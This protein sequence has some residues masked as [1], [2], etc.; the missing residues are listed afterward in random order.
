MKWKVGA[1]VHS[2]SRAAKAKLNDNMEEAN[3]NNANSELLNDGKNRYNNATKNTIGPNN[4]QRLTIFLL[5]NSMIGSGILNQPYVFMKSGVVGALIGF[6]IATLGTWSGLFLLTEA[7]IISN[8]FDF[9]GLARDALGSEGDQ[10]V[11]G[12]IM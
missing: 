6:T 12:S 4:S 11:D 7:G 3:S 5:V 1:L 9:A 8:N 10:L 2:P